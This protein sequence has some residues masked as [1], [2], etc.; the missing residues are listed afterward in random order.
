MS[1]VTLA[2]ARAESPAAD[3]NLQSLRGELDALDSEILDLIGRRMGVA[4]SIGELKGAAEPQ[5]MERKRI[6][7]A[8]RSKGSITCR[9]MLQQS[10]NAP[11]IADQSP[12]SHAR[13]RDSGPDAFSRWT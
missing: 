7:C 11:S 1:P 4:R 2:A 13:T 9:D 5:S 10:K 12:S 8:G 6:Q 3:P